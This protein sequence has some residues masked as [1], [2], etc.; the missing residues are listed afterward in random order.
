[1]TNA[2]DSKSPARLEARISQETKALAQKAADLEGRTLINFEVAS[3]QAAYRV[4]E[5]HLPTEPNIRYC[6]NIQLTY[7]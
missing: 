4:I 1:M 6:R 7:E 2:H 5:H 3:V